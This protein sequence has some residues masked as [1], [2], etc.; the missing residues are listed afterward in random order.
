MSYF[1]LWLDFL[2]VLFGIIATYLYAKGLYTTFLFGLANTIPFAWIFLSNSIYAQ[3]LIHIY[4]SIMNLIGLILW[5]SINKKGQTQYCY[6]SKSQIGFYLIFFVGIFFVILFLYQIFPI[7]S[8]NIQIEIYDTISTTMAIVGM[9]LGVR[10]YID[11]WYWFIASD[12]L[13]II[14]TYQSMLYFASIQFFIYII[15][16]IYGWK[17]WHNKYKSQACSTIF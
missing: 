3:G 7:K 5:Y 12:I 15:L 13:S 6:L 8:Q 4:Y 2:I 1:P 17:N 9:F 11:S 10:Y 16:G 14:L